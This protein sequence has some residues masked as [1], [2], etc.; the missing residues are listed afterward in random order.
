MKIRVLP[1]CFALLSLMVCLPVTAEDLTII[2]T[3]TDGKGKS[4]PS[5][6]Y[7]TQ[8][9]VRTSDGRYDTIMDLESE[10]IIHID[11]KKK[12][13]E[14]TTLEELRQHF[15]QLEENMGGM[16]GAVFGGA[17]EV[18]VT[19]GTESRQVAGYEC[20][21]YLMTIGKKFQFDL[22][23]ARG[24]SAPYHYHDA[25]KMAYAAMGP[26]ASRFDK[27]YEEMKEIDGFPLMTKVDTRVVGLKV[28]STSEATEVR[29]GPIPAD[30]FE[31]PAGYK[32]KKK[33]SLQ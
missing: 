26:M 14:E 11:N 9:K 6:Q 7:I 16:M 3:V 8:N 32:K 20:D 21:H 19:K 2:S 31:P 12:T 27:L 22:W 5:T 29:K 24:L 4:V 17:G 23:A 18:E 33:S 1:V 10:R 13:Y 15:A 28:Q 25:K 30:V